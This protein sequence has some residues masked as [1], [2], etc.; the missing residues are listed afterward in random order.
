MHL[1]RLCVL[2][3]EGSPMS[4]NAVVGDAATVPSP[5]RPPAKHPPLPAGVHPPWPI[6]I[7]PSARAGLGVLATRR[8]PRGTIVFEEEPIVV[9][10]QDPRRQ[11]EDDDIR[12]LLVRCMELT[13]GDGPVQRH[14]GLRYGDGVHPPEVEK[15]MGEIT[16]INARRAFELLPTEAQGLP[17]GQVPL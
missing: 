5:G 12:P 8:I 6:R 17:Q 9:I 7:G 1:L 4:K 2:L 13:A 3:A 14:A 11:L 16:E 15:L 10:N